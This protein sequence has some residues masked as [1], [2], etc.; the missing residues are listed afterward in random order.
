ML[1]STLIVD[2][3]TDG[4]TENRTSISH[5]AKAGA[6]KMI[7]AHLFGYSFVRNTRESFSAYDLSKKVSTKFSL[8]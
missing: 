6:T 2:A 4:Q 7:S 3:K 5:L 1:G 8:K